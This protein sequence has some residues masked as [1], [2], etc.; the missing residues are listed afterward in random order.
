MSYSQV[1][2]QFDSYIFKR[3]TT[4]RPTTAASQGDLTSVI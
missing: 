2:I 1:K 3:V 4:E